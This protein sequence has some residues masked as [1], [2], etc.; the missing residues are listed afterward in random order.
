MASTEG[1]IGNDYRN[2]EQAFFLSKVFLYK[3][4]M[5]FSLK[6]IKSKSIKDTSYLLYRSSLRCLNG[7]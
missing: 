1:L 4:I 2:C 3:T 6:K 7:P 5:F